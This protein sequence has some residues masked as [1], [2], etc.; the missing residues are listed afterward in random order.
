MMLTLLVSA[1]GVGGSLEAYCVG[2]EKSFAAHADA[3][4][5]DGGPKSILTGDVL[6]RRHDAVCASYL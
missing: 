5:E 2:I 6:V 4:A 3:L 1:C